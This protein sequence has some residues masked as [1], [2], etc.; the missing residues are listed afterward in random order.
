MAS[1]AVVLV[2]GD[3]GFGDMV[4]ALGVG[5]ERFGAF[6]GPFHR[7]AELLRREKDERVFVI[8]ER[9]HAE[10]AADVFGDDAQFRV[11]DAEDVLGDAG[12]HAVDALAAGV[13]RVFVGCLVVGAEA[14]ARLHRV[15]DDALVDEL[16]RRDVR[17]LGEGGVG[18]G[19]V[20]QFV[21]ERD[22]RFRLAGGSAL[23]SA[24]ATVSTTAG[25][26]S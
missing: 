21:V 5:Q 13:E 14:G 4:A 12:A 16:Q 19:L 26:S 18:R 8:D 11:F 7:A 24:R 1:D 23:R 2:E 25:S 9:L 22:V 10:A 3:R 20:A 17:G 6:G 15:D